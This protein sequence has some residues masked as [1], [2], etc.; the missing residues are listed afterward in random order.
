MREILYRDA[1]CEAID[2]EMERDDRVLMLGEDVGF[3]GGNF[4]TSVGL[5]VKT[6]ITK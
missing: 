5:C 2:E 3:L 6:V 4:K 1:I